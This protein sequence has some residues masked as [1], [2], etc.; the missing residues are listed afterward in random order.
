MRNNNRTILHIDDDRLFTAII[1]E[2]L[3]AHGYDVV[4]IHSALDAMDELKRGQYRLVLLDIDMPHKD[5]LD[6]LHE[7]KLYDGGIQVVMLT[8]LVNVTTYLKTMQMG[9]EA[10]LFKP[11]EQIEPLLQTLEHT[12]QKIDRWWYPLNDLIQRQ[13]R[14]SMASAAAV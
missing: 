5:G 9:A 8:G 2:R 4:P 7:I 10:C 3:A 13:G 14:K 1:S 6:L 12:Y 11:I